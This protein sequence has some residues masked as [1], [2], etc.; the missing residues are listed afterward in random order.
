MLEHTCEQCGARYESLDDSC[1]ERFSQLLAFDH[2]RKE[3]W[4][5]RHGSAFAAYT[6]QHP[7][8]LPRGALER[9]WVMLYRIWIAGD[10]PEYVAR[11]LRHGGGRPSW[12][13]PP[14]PAE[15]VLPRRARMTIAD[16][17]EFDAETYPS[18][19]EAWCRATLESL[20]QPSK[21]A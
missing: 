11:T 19:L 13:V 2:S 4:G 16:L 1:A 17:G 20:G 15:A 3:P 8:G 7:A 5:S 10:D 18:H 14:L 21:T 6:L 12:H 9:C